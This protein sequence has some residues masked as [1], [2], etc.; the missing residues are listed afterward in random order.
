LVSRN[1]PNAVI[2]DKNLIVK[3][4]NQMLLHQKVQTVSGKTT[5]IRIQTLCLH[6]DTPKALELVET[7]CRHLKHNN[8]SVV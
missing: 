5:P 2:L 8:V 4:V 6:G 1:N 7:I 3:Q